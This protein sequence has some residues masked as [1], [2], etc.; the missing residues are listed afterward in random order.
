VGYPSRHASRRAGY[1]VE[2][3]PVARGRR[4]AGAPP[5][6]AHAVKEPTLLG[7]L[8]EPDG[9]IAEVGIQ[10]VAEAVARAVEAAQQY[11][12]DQLYP[13]VTAAIRDAT[14]RG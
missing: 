2:L 3:G 11:G 1:R 10:R 13:F 4:P 7:E 5:L 8:V 12:V 14:N 9:S 6:P